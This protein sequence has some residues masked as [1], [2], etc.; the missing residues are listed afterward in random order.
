MNYK[1][2]DISKFRKV[3]DLLNN[4]EFIIIVKSQDQI[5]R[6]KSMLQSL[7]Q[8]RYG[9]TME[10]PVESGLFA[11]CLLKNGCIETLSTRNFSEPRHI[12]RYGDDEFLLTEIDAIIH[13]D[14][15]GNTLN[16]YRKPY[17]AYLHTIKLWDDQKRALVASSGYDAIFEFDI[18]SGEIVY[19]WFAWEHG[20]NPSKEGVWLTTKKDKFFVYR[21]EGKKVMMIDPEKYGKKGVHTAYRTV[22]PNLAVYDRYDPDKSILVSFGHQGE[23]FKIDCVSGNCKKVFEVG[24]QMP[25]GLMPYNDG[26]CITNTVKG[27][28]IVLDKDFLIQKVYSIANMGGKVAGT[29]NAEWIQQVICTTDG[30]VIFIDANRGVIAVDLT[31]EVYTR[32]HPNPEWC[33]QDILP[34][35]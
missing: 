14:H 35:S 21:N 3:P 4:T 23:I 25:H 32:Y 18:E 26:W 34:L 16:R 19:E 20:F 33:I 22:H 12:C 10:R 29:E 2:I 31:A 7:K 11:N 15:Q 9:R 8:G 24:S 13:V 30:S 1:T 28:W 27:E 6:R 5:E 17:F